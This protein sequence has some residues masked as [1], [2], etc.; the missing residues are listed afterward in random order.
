MFNFGMTVATLSKCLKGIVEIQQPQNHYSILLQREIAKG[1]LLLIF[2]LRVLVKPKILRVGWST[3]EL[4]ELE[5]KEFVVTGNI[6][7]KDTTLFVRK[8]VEGISVF[9]GW[10][11]SI[12]PVH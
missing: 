4:A 2:F 6:Q 12:T 11:T 9:C 10:L 8:I 5:G 7:E 3:M 1:V